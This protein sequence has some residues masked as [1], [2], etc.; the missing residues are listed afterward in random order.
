MPRDFPRSDRV[1]SLL[2]RELSSL[3]RDE[4]KDPALHSPA[5]IEVEVNRDLSVAKVFFSVLDEAHAEETT[6]ALNHASG[7]LRRE[8]GHRLRLR[9][10][11][12]LQFAFDD[13]DLK[14]QKLD[15]LIDSALTSKPTTSE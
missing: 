14:A 7:Y 8:L 12:H 15:A 5:V 1:A 9:F 13:T 10:T 11:P 6:Q 3:I 2:Q 4:L